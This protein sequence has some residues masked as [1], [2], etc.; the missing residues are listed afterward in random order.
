MIVLHTYGDSHASFHGSW[1]AIDIDGVQILTNWLGPKLMYSFGRD[2]Q[3]VIRPSQIKPKDYI[4]FCYGEIDCRCHVNLYEPNWKESIDKMVEE[5]FINIANNVL[6]L[7]VRVCVYNVPPMLERSDS[8]IIWANE[9]NSK[10][11]LPIKGS[12]EQRK[13]YALYMN[14]KLK[15]YCGK[16]G[17]IFFDVYDKYT[18]SSGF[19][20][21]KLSDGNCHIGDSRFIKEELIKIITI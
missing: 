2:K 9:A 14:T 3:I 12:N 6:G 10:D 20:D 11:M 8:E 1:T 7:D 5:Y 4:L 13:K 18:N 16:N 19:L 21:V 15:E 17:Y